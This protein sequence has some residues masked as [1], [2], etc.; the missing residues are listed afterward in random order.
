LNWWV[1]GRYLARGQGAGIDNVG[2]ILLELLS[3]LGQRGTGQ[4]H[5]TGAGGLKNTEGTDE[6]EEGVD[7]VRLGGAIWR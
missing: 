3:L 7:A 2:G 4:S 1:G 6:L 5:E